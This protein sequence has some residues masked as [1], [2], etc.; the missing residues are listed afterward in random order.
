MERNVSKLS[1]LAQAMMA[2][3]TAGKLLGTF[4]AQGNKREEIGLMKLATHLNR[5][6]VE[7]GRLMILVAPEGLDPSVFDAAITKASDDAEKL[8]IAAITAEAALE[9][10]K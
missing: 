8:E 4:D 7:A 2:M 5:A 10:S 1:I 9:D 3:D 6:A